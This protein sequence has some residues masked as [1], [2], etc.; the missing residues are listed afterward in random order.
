MRSVANIFYFNIPSLG[1]EIKSIRESPRIEYGGFVFLG[2]Y[3]TEKGK[4]TLIDI[5]WQNSKTCELISNNEF[6][7]RFFIC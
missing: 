7:N 5:K 1:M 4:T 6:I 2:T 3:L